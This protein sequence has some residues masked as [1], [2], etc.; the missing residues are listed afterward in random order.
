MEKNINK[1]IEKGYTQA[2]IAKEI[3]V[4]FQYLSMCKLGKRNSSFVESQVK[5]LLNSK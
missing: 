4:S 1:L 5:Q 2:Q 3:G